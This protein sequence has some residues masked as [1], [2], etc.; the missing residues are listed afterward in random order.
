MKRIQIRGIVLLVLMTFLFVGC[1]SLER[2][3]QQTLDTGASQTETTQPIETT[4][5][6]EITHPTETQPAKQPTEEDLRQWLDGFIQ[7]NIIE[8]DENSDLLIQ[9]PG[10]D[11]VEAV[12]SAILNQKNKPYTV[13]I[14]CDTVQ[15]DTAET[16]G[17]RTLYKGSALALGRGWSDS[18]LDTHFLVVYAEYTAEYNHT[19]T[20]E[21]DGKIAMYAYMVRD[22]A[23]GL[24]YICDSMTQRLAE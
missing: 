7:S 8:P 10:E 5:P 12:R 23:S 21:F 16:E 11:P 19:L 13:S 2:I 4:Q 17:Q 18:Y 9:N 20:P 6:T 15:I 14:S 3:P 24:W 1:T 22:P